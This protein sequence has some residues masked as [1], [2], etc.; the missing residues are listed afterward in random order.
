MYQK[1]LFK[2]KNNLLAILILYRGVS[3]IKAAEL[4]ESL[5]NIGKIN[6]TW[7]L[8]PIGRNYF[9]FH[10]EDESDYVR[11]KHYGQS[12]LK[13]GIIKLSNWVPDFVPNKQKQNNAH[14]WTRIHELPF[15]YFDEEL[16]LYLAGGIG[17]A[18]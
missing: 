4:Q 10:F 18:L 5:N 13:F 17:T 14:M 8:T 6:N 16:V 12:K 9:V 11:I 15:E 7:S 1:A 2:C 3:P